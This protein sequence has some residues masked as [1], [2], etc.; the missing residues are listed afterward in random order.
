[1]DTI[2]VVITKVDRR[3]VHFRLYGKP[4]FIWMRP[5]LAG[6]KPGMKIEIAFDRKNYDFG[7]IRGCKLL[8]S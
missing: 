7:P 4:V 5:S 1:M 6:A 8:T 2:V 3:Y